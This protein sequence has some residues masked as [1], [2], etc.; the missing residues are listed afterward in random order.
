MADTTQ[1]VPNLGSAGTL[2]STDLLYVV[3][4]NGTADRKVTLA[5]LQAGLS[6]TV[7]VTGATGLAGSTGAAGATGATGAGIN[8]ATGATGVGTTGATG[9]A[10]AT[11]ATGV[12]GGAGLETGYNYL[13]ITPATGANLPVVLGVTGTDDLI[14]LVVRSKGSSFVGIGNTGYAP[15]AWAGYDGGLELMVAGATANTSGCFPL[16]IESY[17]ASTTGAIASGLY[18][19][20]TNAVNGPTPD[21]IIGGDFWSW[22]GCGTGYN[23]APS[24]I[25]VNSLAANGSSNTGAGGDLT[26]AIA[27]S[28]RIGSWG[29]NTVNAVA[30]QAAAAIPLNGT[31]DNLYGLKVEDQTAGTAGNWAIKT[32]L[33][34]VEFGD[35]VQ[36]NSYYLA[37]SRNGGHVVYDANGLTRYSNV[38]ENEHAGD[39][40][41]VAESFNFLTGILDNNVT[42]AITINADGSARFYHQVEVGGALTVLGATGINGVYVNGSTGATLPV[43][44]LATGSDTDIQLRLRGKGAGTVAMGPDT[45]GKYPNYQ[46]YLE[47]VSFSPALDPNI[48]AAYFEVL[49]KGS[50]AAV[51]VGNEIYAYGTTAAFSEY[52]VAGNKIR[53]AGQGA[54]GTTLTYLTGTEVIALAGNGGGTV[55]LAKGAEVGVWNLGLGTISTGYGLEI[56][57]AVNDGG[58]TFT[59]N[60]GLKI[61]DQTVGATGNNWAIKAGKGKVELGNNADLPA[62]FQNW[63]NATYGDTKLNVIAVEDGFALGVNAHSTGNTYGVMGAYFAVSGK[64]PTG[65]EADAFATVSCA[66]TSGGYFYIESMGTGATGSVVVD[67]GK[68][69]SLDANV[70]GGGQFTELIGLNVGNITAGATGANYAI[71]T[72]LG[73]VDLGDDLFVGTTDKIQLHGATGANL[74]STISVTGSTGPSELHLEGQGT[75]GFVS[76]GNAPGLGVTAW[77]GYELGLEMTMVG[78]TGAA[79]QTGIY[80]TVQGAT[81]ANASVGGGNIQAWTSDGAT[82]NYTDQCI[83]FAFNGVAYH[84]TGGYTNDLEGMSAEAANLGPGLVSLAYGVNGRIWNNGGGTIAEAAALNARITNQSG[85]IYNAYGLYIEAITAGATGNYAIKSEAGAVDFGGSLTFTPPASISPGVTGA[86]TFEA[87]SDTTLTVKYKGSDGVVRSGTIALAP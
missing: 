53:A 15:S 54:T 31:I 78:T 85:T 87:T 19:S 83:G 38:A 41:L 56:G 28:G 62:A 21:A 71:K 23:P 12:G 72:G 17:A 79:S 14:K 43:T 13:Y 39:Y 27:I 3:Q 86:L 50:T 32:G 69:I 2:A 4:Q 40:Q 73:A 44:I 26:Q 80:G 58:G 29:G 70:S 5:A 25:G 61:G 36:T 8:G 46:T 82:G 18:C 59:N 45:Y 64:L 37:G 74:R 77:N 7:G 6:G 16:W 57:P 66:R 9:L 1:T 34:L 84:A 10:G 52:V 81:K 22:S 55:A 51:T 35:T 30:L 48:T 24:V 47:V 68:V 63:T 11:G 33:G 76:I 75:Y 67:S 60:Y 20:V 65:F 42:N 49:S